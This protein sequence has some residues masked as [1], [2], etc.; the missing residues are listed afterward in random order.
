ME[1]VAFAFLQLFSVLFSILVTW[2]FISQKYS[3]V[4]EN[5]KFENAKLFNELSSRE[6]DDKSSDTATVSTTSMKLIDASKI[7]ME[8]VSAILSKQRIDLIELTSRDLQLNAITAER[9]YW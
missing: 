9:V 1:F 4:I 2:W 7:K 6:E 8:E 3:K 5:L